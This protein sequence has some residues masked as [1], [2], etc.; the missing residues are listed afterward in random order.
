VLHASSKA[1]LEFRILTLR[2]LAFKLIVI[3]ATWFVL[4]LR[5]LF[6]LGKHGLMDVTGM[7]MNDMD[8]TA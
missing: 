8:L 5:E 4:G 2:H 6:L 3:L 1:W 7:A